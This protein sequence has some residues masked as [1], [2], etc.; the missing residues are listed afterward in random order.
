[1]TACDSHYIPRYPAKPSSTISRSVCPVILL[2][3]IGDY[4]RVIV[5]E[6]GDV[7][8]DGSPTALLGNPSS[9]LARLAAELNGAAASRR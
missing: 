5:M 3:H 9:M 1:M 2:Q 6:D 4:D 7:A 8:E